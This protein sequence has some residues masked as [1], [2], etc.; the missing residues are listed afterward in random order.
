M[1][2]RRIFLLV[3]RS[4]K[5]RFLVSCIFTPQRTFSAFDKEIR[6]CLQDLCSKDLIREELSLLPSVEPAARGT[7]A[8]SF[9]A[10]LCCLEYCNTPH[11]LAFEFQELIVLIG[12]RITYRIRARIDAKK[13]TI[14]FHVDS[15]L[16]VCYSTRVVYLPHRL[17]LRVQIKIYP[18]RRLCRPHSVCTRRQPSGCRFYY[19]EIL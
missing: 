18:N 14:S 9:L 2:N 6:I 19:T 4:F 12:Y 13:I 16:E 11:G 5:R 17:T 10:L 3:P 1:V 8:S 7:V 15:L